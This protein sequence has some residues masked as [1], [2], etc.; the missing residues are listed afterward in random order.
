M[1][2]NIQDVNEADMEKDKLMHF[3][4]SFLICLALC[5]LTRDVVSS[6]L[7]TML[8]GYSKELY[9]KYC[10]HTYID[11]QDL[12]ADGTGTVFAAG[13]WWFS[14]VLPVILSYR[15]MVRSWE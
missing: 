6:I 3:G 7:V 12:M 13:I 5:N 10:K 15:D 9:D 14:G 1:H 2:Y 8:I 4:I 11:N